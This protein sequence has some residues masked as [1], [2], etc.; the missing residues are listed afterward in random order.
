MYNAAASV[1]IAL[2]GGPEGMTRAIRA[3]DPALASFAVRRYMLAPRDV[4]GDNEASASS[5]AAFLRKL[6]SGALDGVDAPTTTAIRAAMLTRN[7]LFGLPG[8]HHVKDGAL[9]SNPLVRVLSGWREPAEKDGTIMVYV[10][11][12]SQPGPGMLPRD[13][14]GERLEE[15]AKKIAAITILGK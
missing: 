15:T 9:N 12:L 3:R 13:K 10:I 8:R 4:T 2:L 6:A 5:L 14:A 11:M 1:S 7:D